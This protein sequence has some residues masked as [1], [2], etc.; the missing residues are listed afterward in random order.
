MPHKHEM[1]FL[2]DSWKVLLYMY[3]SFRLLLAP[4]ISGGHFFLT[5]FFCITH[6]GLSERGFGFMN[7]VDN[8]NWPP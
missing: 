8:V 3:I 7:K 4:W 1:R 5:I 6:D 2:M